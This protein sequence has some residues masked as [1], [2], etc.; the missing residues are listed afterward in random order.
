MTRMMAAAALVLAA[1]CGGSAPP[2][3]G[4][5]PDGQQ[6]PGAMPMRGMG[7][8]G[9]NV[10]ALIGAREQLGLSGTQV[11]ELDSI[12]RGWAVLND[13]LQ[14][15]LREDSGDR[16]PNMERVRPVLL[17]MAENNEAANLAVQQVLTDEQER[18]AC[19]LPM[20]QQ[21]QRTGPPP[22]G[23]RR[24]GSRGRRGQVGPGDTVPEIS[25][26]RGWPWCGLQAPADSAG[27]GAAARSP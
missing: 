16:R 1:A 26:R 14:R 12:G 21:R 20:A 4:P 5:E 15:Q 23:S 8:G 11:V 25:M 10:F 27:A 22:P 24:V 9:P 13:S 7:G 6:A 18:G 3:E 17:R 19:A 2:G